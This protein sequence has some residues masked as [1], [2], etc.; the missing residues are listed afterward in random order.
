MS[1]TSTW[2]REPPIPAASKVTWSELIKRYNLEWFYSV[3]LHYKK[4]FSEVLFASLFL[5]SMGLLLPLFTQVVIDKVIGN[6]G[7]STLTVL[8]TGLL[9][10]ALPAIAEQFLMTMV[11]YV[12]TAMVG[13]PYSARGSSVT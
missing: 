10:L 12:D 1:N 11:S 6:D 13:M 8:G 7:M 9:V 2:A 3:I 5:Q 4:Y